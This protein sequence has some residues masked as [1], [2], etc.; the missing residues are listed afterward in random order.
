MSGKWHSIRFKGHQLRFRFGRCRFGFH[1]RGTVAG[2]NLGWS[3]GLGV[4][5]VSVW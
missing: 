4:V 2:H 1:R 5:I 3:A